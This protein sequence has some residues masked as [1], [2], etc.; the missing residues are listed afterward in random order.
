MLLVIGLTGLAGSGKSEVSSHLMAS[1]GFAKFVFS[2]IIREEANKRSLLGGKAYEDQKAVLS[3]LGETLRRES[4]RWDILAIRLAE[5]ISSGGYERVVVDGFRSA[6]EVELFRKKF[7]RF[8]LI[9]IEANEKARFERRKKE[10]NFATIEGIRSRDR[11]DIKELGLGKV[12]KLA[13]FRA[14]NNSSIERLQKEIDTI[15]S[16]VTD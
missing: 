2:D 9:L 10:D 11:R 4:G 1:H 14:N 13:D 6:E 15:L 16:K 7:D 8:F 5:K 3:E 12:I